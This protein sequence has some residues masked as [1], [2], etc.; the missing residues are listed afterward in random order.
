MS[1]SIYDLPDDSAAEAAG[2]IKTAE[3]SEAPTYD[4]PANGYAADKKAGEES[5]GVRLIC[6][7][8]R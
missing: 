5:S 3:E 1:A 4:G 6:T 7:W 2:A 8:A